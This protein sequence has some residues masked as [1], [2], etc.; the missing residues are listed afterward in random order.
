MWEK[1]KDWKR[2]KPTEK[3]RKGG[4]K[5]KAWKEQQENGREKRKGNK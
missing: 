3:W 4:R 2:R 5:G 1:R